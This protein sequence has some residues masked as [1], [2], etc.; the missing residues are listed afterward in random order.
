MYGELCDSCGLKHTAV[1]PTTAIEPQQTTKTN[2][3]GSQHP[4][5]VVIEI[6]LPILQTRE[7]ISWQHGHGMKAEEKSIEDYSRGD[8]S[9]DVNSCRHVVPGD[10]E[11][12]DVSFLQ[13]AYR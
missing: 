13:Y 12:A 2:F 5:D 9:G 3:I 8:L 11:R 6:L 1:V 10:N 4:L 7:A